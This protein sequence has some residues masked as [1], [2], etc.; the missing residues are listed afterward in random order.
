MSALFV[1][2]VPVPQGSHKAFVVKG[3]AVVTS[4]NNAALKPWRK[5]IADAAREAL[6]PIEK[7]T[8]VRVE[9]GFVFERPASV[10]RAAPTVRPDVDKLARAVLDA[11][12]ESGAFADDSQV[13]DLHVTKVYGPQAGAHI[14]VSVA[15]QEKGMAA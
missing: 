2:G 14:R 12:T 10:K 15:D 13:V 7:A 11:L 3:R 5:A 9:V 1:F 4:V 6:T 8:P